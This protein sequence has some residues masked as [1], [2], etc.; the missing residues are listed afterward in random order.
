[1]TCLL[2]LNEVMQYRSHSMSK[3]DTADKGYIKSVSDLQFF[4]LFIEYL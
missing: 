3:L 1:M 2:T 4:L